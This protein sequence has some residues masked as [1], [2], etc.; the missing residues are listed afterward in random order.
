MQIHQVSLTYQPE[1]DRLLLRVSSTAG[2]ELRLWLT[3]RLMLGL[4]PMLSRLQT[5]QLLKMESAGSALHGADEDLRRMVADF[6]KEEF[7]QHADFDTPWQDQA[8]LPLGA[9]PMLVTDVDAAPLP[10]GR[11]RLSMN[12]RAS[13]GGRD[14]PRGFQLELDARLMHGLVHLL[15]QAL[16]QAQWR[17][18]FVPPTA[19][20]DADGEAGASPPRY[21]N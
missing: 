14:K 19:V 8:K 18:P 7:L 9:E 17:E 13:V 5:E 12:E 2:Q 16:T 11:A 4:W 3:R 10:D 6:R 15:D 21:L 1:Q 20:H